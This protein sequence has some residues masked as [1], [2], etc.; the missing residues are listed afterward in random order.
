MAPCGVVGM[1]GG[2]LRPAGPEGAPEPIPPPEVSSGACEAPSLPNKHGDPAAQAVQRPRKHTQ[3]SWTFYSKF[4]VC[5]SV[6]DDTWHSVNVPISQDPADS[7]AG[8]VSCPELEQYDE[9]LTQVGWRFILSYT[10]QGLDA[11]Y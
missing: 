7:A 1:E 8:P 9:S 3:V 5:V 10:F 2:P 6:C 11:Q 4:Q